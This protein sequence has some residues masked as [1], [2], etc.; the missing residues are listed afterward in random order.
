MSGKDQASRANPPAAGM[1]KVVVDP[2]VPAVARQTLTRGLPTGDSYSEDDFQTFAAL[3]PAAFVVSLPLGGLSFWLGHLAHSSWLQQ[4]M[5]A[6]VD[7]VGFG[8]FALGLGMVACAAVGF[9]L[10]HAAGLIP[11][12]F[13]RRRYRRLATAHRGRFVVLADLDTAARKVAK[14]ALKAG[15]RTNPIRAR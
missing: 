13:K 10:F 5:L 11:L 7:V 14:R 15:G 12:A 6:G 4:G 1:I 3:A 2:D 8:F 9:A